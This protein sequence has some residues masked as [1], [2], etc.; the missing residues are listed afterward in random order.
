MAFRRLAWFDEF[1]RNLWRPSLFR[2]RLKGASSMMDL[3]RR[4]FL[5]AVTGAAVGSTVAGH[6][7]PLSSEPLVA[8]PAAARQNRDEPSLPLQS[9]VFPQPQ[10]ISASDGDFVL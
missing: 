9:L 8:L 1:F 6:H 10:Q 3:T 4:E 7:S 2:R 5:H